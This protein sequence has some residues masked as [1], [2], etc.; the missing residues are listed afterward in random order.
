[1]VCHSSPC[2]PFFNWS[3]S[4]TDFEC[5]FLPLL[6]LSYYISKMLFCQNKKG[7]KRQDGT[8]FDHFLLCL[9]P[10]WEKRRTLTLGFTSENLA[11]LFAWRV[12]PGTRFHLI[13]QGTFCPRTERGF[14]CPPLLR[15][16][17]LLLALS[18]FAREFV[19]QDTPSACR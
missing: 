2:L 5:T 9:Q 12:G 18:S 11:A 14:R 4:S 17:L 6:L 15:Q 10:F 19:L 1:M 8:W 13:A 16:V 3:G 7:L